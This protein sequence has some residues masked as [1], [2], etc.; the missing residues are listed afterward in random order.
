MSAGMPLVIVIA[1]LATVGEVYVLSSEADC[2]MSRPARP[3]GADKNAT[4]T[5]FLGGVSVYL[6]VMVAV[7][8]APAWLLILAA[9]FLL[10]AW[11]PFAANYTTTSPGFISL[12]IVGAVLIG[13][14]QVYIYQATRP[15]LECSLAL[16]PTIHRMRDSRGN[17]MR[18]GQNDLIG[19]LRIRQGNGVSVRHVDFLRVT[20]DVDADFGSYIGAFSK[21]GGAESIDDLEKA[22]GLSRPFFH[23]SWLVPPDS[24][25]KVDPTDEEFV[26]V[27]ITKSMG[28]IIF[29][30]AATQGDS[31]AVFGFRSTGHTPKYSMTTPCWSQL[32]E[33]R[34]ANSVALTGAYPQLRKEV[35]DGA[36]KIQ[37]DVDGDFIDIAP[38]QIT[39]PWSA[40]LPSD[41]RESA[42]DLFYGVDNSGE[43]LALP[44][45]E[46]P[47]LERE[48][49]K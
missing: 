49:R 41:L 16:V 34:Q 46:N 44:A 9:I 12:L 25:E 23:L 48:K 18:G 47:L 36:V 6:T 42:E 30:L 40:S 39:F 3:A 38:G 13:A 35:R 14:L 22:Y 24:R 1:I 28:A 37:V 2:G 17:Y 4:G 10:I 32:I 26:R 15:V 43:M 45:A 29:P 33:F 21:G 27:T 8:K 5:L 7:V 31:K 11:W 19:V 20:G